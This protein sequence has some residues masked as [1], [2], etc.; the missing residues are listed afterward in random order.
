LQLIYPALLNGTHSLISVQ[1]RL[2]RVLYEREFPQNLFD[3]DQLEMTTPLVPIVTI[4][5]DVP[6][7]TDDEKIPESYGKPSILSSN[8]LE[9]GTPL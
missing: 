3:T 2:F 7:R 4:G 5:F 8:F 6:D 9:P 1:L